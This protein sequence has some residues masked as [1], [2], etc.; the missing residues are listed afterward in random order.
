ML[1]AV[2]ATCAQ[3]DDW[4]GFRIGSHAGGGWGDLRNTA[5]DAKG[6]F[7]AGFVFRR[8]LQGGLGGVHV[9]YDHQIGKFV[10]GIEG[11]FSWTGI[12]GSSTSASPLVAGTSATATSHLEWIATL[13]GRLGLNVQDHWLVFVKAGAAWAENENRA[14]IRNAAGAV[15]ANNSIHENREGWTIGG[16]VEWAFAK[17][18]SARAEYDYVDFGSEVV[19][20]YSTSVATGAVT[21]FTSDVDLYFHLAR[22]GITYRFGGAH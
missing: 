16:G 2:V 8:D 13:T 10:L 20:G 12:E 22:V 4:S 5:V 9:G 7:P 6:P 1:V 11:D 15:V 3:A 18:W 21:P 14:S 19:V 17:H